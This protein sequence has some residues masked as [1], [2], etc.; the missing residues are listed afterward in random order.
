MVSAPQQVLKECN[1]CSVFFFFFFNQYIPLFCF[2]GKELWQW[3]QRT[4]LV[5]IFTF[6]LWIF[7]QVSWGCCWSVVN[8]C[9]N[10]CNCSTPGFPVL[11]HLPEIVQTQIHWSWW[12][13]STIS[14]S[15]VPFSSC[16]QSFQ[17]QGLSQRVSPL[18]Q[19]ANILGVSASASVL[20]V[21]IQL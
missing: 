15:V 4:D 2:M 3:I 14:S 17:H 11:H 19:V 12:C 18:H 6:E 9:L 5:P 13:H 21:N 8:S 20:P 7:R 1:C 16:L 10:F